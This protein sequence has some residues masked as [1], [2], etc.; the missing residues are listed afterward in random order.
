MYLLCGQNEH[1]VNTN[2]MV[3]TITKLVKR[4]NC[5]CTKVSSRINDK[6]HKMYKVHSTKFGAPNFLT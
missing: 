5:T 1:F 4:V 2:K 6:L 3:H